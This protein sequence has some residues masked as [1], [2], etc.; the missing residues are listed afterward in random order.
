VGAGQNP[1]AEDAVHRLAR[2]GR[3]EPQ[4][5]EAVRLRAESANLGLELPAPERITEDAVNKVRGRV[6]D[7]SRGSPNESL[8]RVLHG[9][10]KLPQLQL[11]PETR[12]QLRV[13][14]FSP[15][16][17]VRPQGVQTLLKGYRGGQ[18]PAAT[19]Q[20]FEGLLQGRPEAEQ[21]QLLRG[22]KALNELR[23]AGKISL[24]ARVVSG[25][26]AGPR[27][28]GTASPK[29]APLKLR[30]HAG[31]RGIENM[32]VG[33]PAAELSSQKTKTKK[34]TMKPE[35]QRQLL[36]LQQALTPGAL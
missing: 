11:L 20:A 24:P 36:R 13:L 26:G 29:A 2:T 10:G 5:N 16:E 27:I 3:G 6:A 7:Y 28:Y 35:K 34:S 21:L 8:E 25:G 9:R 18:Q 12:Q 23:S 32:S 15:E 14:G 31:L 17:G 19:E 1:L 33:G 30:A 22:L 4:L